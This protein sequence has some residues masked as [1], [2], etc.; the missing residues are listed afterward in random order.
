MH[1]GDVALVVQVVG[2]RAVAGIE[3]GDT[4][5]GDLLAGV[6]GLLQAR[7]DELGEGRQVRLRLQVAVDRRQPYRPGAQAVEEGFQAFVGVLAAV[8]LPEAQQVDLAFLVDEAVEIFL[9]PRVLVVRQHGHLAARVAIDVVADQVAQQAH[10]GQV[11]RL[12][13]GVLDGRDAPVVFLAEVVEGVDAAAGEE[14]FVGARRIFPLQRGLEHRRQ[15]AVLVGDQVVDGPFADEVQRHDLDVLQFFVGQVRIVAMQRGNH[16]EITG[17]HAQLGG[18][19]ELQLAAFVDVERLVGVV[20]LH[21]HAVAAGGAFEQGEAVAHVLG[22]VLGQ[23]ALAEQADF[24]G[25]GGV[26]EFL[27][28]DA[29]LFLQFVLQGG[30]ERHVE[31]VE[32]IQRHVEHAGQAGARQ[33]HALVGFQRLH[34]RLAQRVAE[35][36]LGLE[37][38]V[39][40]RSADDVGLGQQAQV[41]VGQLGEGFASACQVIGRTAV[42]DHQRNHLAQRLALF[43]QVGTAGGRG[44]QQLVDP[45]EVAAVPDPQAVG[46]A[47]DLAVTGLR[48]ERHRVEVGEHDGLPRLDVFRAAHVAAHAGRGHLP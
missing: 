45:L 26:G 33:A 28:V 27:Q 21:P 37:R 2:T 32:V 30:G 25:E 20:G 48:G 17:Q 6:L 39:A 3:V 44:A 16:F 18:G 22:L 29:D 14:A 4:F 34:G 40:Q 35:A 19:A 12:A 13:Q 1:A 43:L 41:A 47:A 15:A 36:Q 11:D 38:C 42:G 9:A 24:R 23:Q 5:V 10:E 46:Q 8:F 7:L 31:T